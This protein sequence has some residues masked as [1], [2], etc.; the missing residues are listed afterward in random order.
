MVII[1]DNYEEETQSL[2]ITDPINYMPSLDTMVG[3]KRLSI[4][5][6]CRI[7]TL[8][9]FPTN[10]TYLFVWKNRLTSIPSIP[11]SIV[12]F[13]V[14]KNNMTIIPERVTKILYKASLRQ[15][16]T[17]WLNYKRLTQFV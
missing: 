3:L 12:T 7:K 10:L 4:V 1:R 14:C 11:A 15:K 6:D 13:I 8:P 2:R 5:G 17:R 16:S 9:T